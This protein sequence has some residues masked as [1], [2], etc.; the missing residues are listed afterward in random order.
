ML[1]VESKPGC[2]R[3]EYSMVAQNWVNLHSGSKLSQYVRSLLI[4]FGR[5]GCRQ[6]ASPTPGRPNE[7]N[8]IIDQINLTIRSSSSN[9]ISSIK[10]WAL[11]IISSTRFASLRERPKSNEGP[12][13][14][15][16]S[17]L[18]WL[19]SLRRLPPVGRGSPSYEPFLCGLSPHLWYSWSWAPQRS[20]FM[21]F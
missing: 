7:V 9:W 5:S 18:G 12:N 19:R 3:Y 20:C 13:S 1:H 11:D 2:W 8:W 15:T 6:L 10:L 14:I 16:K 21:C 17:L 4:K